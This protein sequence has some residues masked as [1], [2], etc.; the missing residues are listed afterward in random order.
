M[1]G[2]YPMGPVADLDFMMEIFRFF[3]ENFN[4]YSP[5]ASTIDEYIMHRTS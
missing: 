3:R 4:R 2:Q 1:N 5:G